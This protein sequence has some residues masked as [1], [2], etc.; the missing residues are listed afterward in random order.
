MGDLDGDGVTDLVVGAPGIDGHGAIYVFFL[1]NEMGVRSCVKI[2]HNQEQS[3][4]GLTAK[5]DDG[6]LFGTALADIGDLDGD[7]CTDIVVGAPGDDDGPR[8][9][10][11]RENSGA[12]YV[13]Y[14]N[15]EGNVKHWS[16]ISAAKGNL[17]LGPAIGEQF[18]TSIVY[19]ADPDTNGHPEIAVGAPYYKSES[20]TTDLQEEKDPLQEGQ[21]AV[22]LLELLPNGD[23]KSFAILSKTR[24]V[25]NLPLGRTPYE[26]VELD[27]KPGDKFGS[28]L[29]STDFNLDGFPDL[30]VGISGHRE[31]LSVAVTTDVVENSASGAIS[32]GPP[33]GSLQKLPAGPAAIL[34][35]HPLIKAG[36]ELQEGVQNAVD[37]LLPVVV[38]STTP[39]DNAVDLSKPPEG[40]LGL[41]LLGKREAISKVIEF[42]ADANFPLV[43]GEEFG[44]SLAYI[45]GVYPFLLIG[46]PGEPLG[47]RGGSVYLYFCIAY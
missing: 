12:V 4:G 31:Q 10:G 9:Q 17:I 47:S 37:A 7:G 25:S 15:K 44:T 42:K 18:G 40:G 8:K 41:L 6:D 29:A 5:F 38:D 13:L 3:F 1:T 23:V 33:G 46:A 22:Y 11:P 34:D 36:L 21:G 39:D 27:I 26:Y 32:P 30:A 19:L 28:A 20:L 24:P 16:K 35:S 14:M 43:P 2:G 45:Q